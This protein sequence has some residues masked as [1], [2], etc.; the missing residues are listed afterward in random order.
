MAARRDPLVSLAR[1]RRLETGTARRRLAE[2]A[3]RLLATEGRAEAADAALRTE[4]KI[5]AAADYAAW[6]GRGLAE[7]NRAALGAAHAAERFALG[8]AALAEARVAERCI[9]R[10]MQQQAAVARMKLR[11]KAQAVA[12]DAAGRKAHTGGMGREQG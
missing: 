4:G 6:L 7:R 9:E 12:D 5:G 2:E 1:L 11:H 10:L 3:D 8:Q